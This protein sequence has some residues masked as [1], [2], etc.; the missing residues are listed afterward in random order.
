MT[1]QILPL[2]PEDAPDVVRA[3]RQH[4]EDADWTEAYFPKV[5]RRRGVCAQKATLDGV[6]AGVHLAV[7]G[8]HLTSAHAPLYHAIALKTAGMNVYTG[9]M[10]YVAPFARGRGVAGQLI[11]R[12]KREMRAAGVALMLVECVV[13]PDGSVPGHVA[14]RY[15]DVY[16]DLGV[17]PLFYI[18][19]PIDRP[20]L[21][22]GQNPCVCGV[23][24]TLY[25]V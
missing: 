8:V 23:Q 14:R 16:E 24:V 12:A 7:Q 9:D 19:E 5:M 22:C 3:Y 10:V 13:A 4:F 2:L 21:I 20:C 1:L 17:Y 6:F 15:F 18:D 11:E 25:R